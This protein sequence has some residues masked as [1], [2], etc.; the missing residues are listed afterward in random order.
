[1]GLLSCPGSI[2]QAQFACE[3]RCGATDFALGDVLGRAVSDDFAAL[4]TGAWADVDDPIRVGESSG[5]F[6]VAVNQDD[7]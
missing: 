2:P 1:M 4:V 7:N 3:E 6:C 5:G